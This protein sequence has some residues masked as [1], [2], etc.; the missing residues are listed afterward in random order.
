[1]LLAETAHLVQKRGVALF[2]SQR[3]LVVTRAK[4]GKRRKASTGGKGAS[5]PKQSVIINLEPD[6]SDLWRLDTVIDQLRQGAVR[7]QYH[8]H[9]HQRVPTWA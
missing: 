8:L 4:G 6:G 9:D 7:L 5:K 2:S 3:E 1:M